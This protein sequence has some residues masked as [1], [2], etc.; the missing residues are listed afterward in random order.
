MTR[1]NKLISRF[2]YRVSFFYFLRKIENK[3][4]FVPPFFILLFYKL[5]PQLHDDYSTI[6][7]ILGT[8]FYVRDLTD[9]LVIKETFYDECY[10]TLFT[11]LKDETTL[12]DIGSYIGDVAIYSKKYPKIKKIIVVE[13]DP[14][15]LEILKRNLKL[16][17]LKNIEIVQ[18]AISDTN[19]YAYLNLGNERIASSLLVPKSTKCRIKVPTIT[20]SKILKL[21]KT[22]N[23]ILKSDCEGAEYNF[24]IST[25]LK[26][27]SRISKMI[28]EYHMN[29]RKLERVMRYL[30]SAGFRTTYEDLIL[31]P[32]VGMAYSNK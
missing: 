27:L 17:N 10:K 5:Y 32:N 20:L 23:I 18:S 2:N 7:K 26:T 1:I 30:K 21:V 15:N 28:F 8:K 4:K 14:R 16:N 3:L 19:G 11:N 13:P 31:E 25:P 29:K 22:K 6:I 12:I 24:L 9:L